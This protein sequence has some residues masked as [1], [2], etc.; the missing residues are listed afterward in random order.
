MNKRSL[1]ICRGLRA[2]PLFALLLL[3]ATCERRPLE[4]ITP[5]YVQ[6]TI[7]N[8]WLTRFYEL[9]KYDGNYRRMPTGMTVMLWGENSN[10]P[11]V[12]S[13]NSD[14]ITVNLPVDRYRLIIF[15]QTF[16]DFHYQSFFEANSYDDMVMRA[17]RYK[18]ST[19][20]DS[21]VTDYMH[22]PDPVGVS[23][24][25]FDISQDMVDRDT[26]IFVFYDDYLNNG[27]EAYAGKTY[28]YEIPEMSWPMTVLLYIK[29]KV[30]HFLSIKSVE[31]NISGM[32]DGFYFSQIRRTSE[33]GTL[34]L[35]GWNAT[36]VGEEADSTA[37]LTDSIASFG[38]PYGKELV[39]ERDS[40]DNILTF[41]I[42]LINDSV[43]QYTYKVAKN[44]RYIKPDGTEAQIR[45]RQDLQNI[46]LEIDL[47]DQIVVP[48]VPPKPG[49]A[50]FDAKV[51][52]WEDGGTFEFGGF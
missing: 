12:E 11:I 8:D 35:T 39:S 9:G 47:P 16:S 31:A 1:K 26:T 5:E 28:R 44:M 7:V 24:D 10:S 21:Y 52:P 30:K 46:R 22:Y 6:V 50:G 2:L 25:T 37:I 38:M 33:T 19:G 3:L 41:N 32:A 42:T 14:R 48:P 45:Y 4:V 43:V 29:A 51:D 18:N 23:L 15:N 17:N 13:R 36:I 40:A 20:W 49:G 27:A 34:K